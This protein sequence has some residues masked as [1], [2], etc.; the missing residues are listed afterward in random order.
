MYFDPSQICL[1]ILCQP[2]WLYGLSKQTTEERLDFRKHTNLNRAILFF[3][4]MIL[5]LFFFSIFILFGD[6][7][8]HHTAII[9]ILYCQPTGL[10]QRQSAEHFSIGDTGRSLEHCQ[11]TKHLPWK[12]R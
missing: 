3:K 4:Y 1:Q 8:Q 9:P 10:L 12:N 7:Q 6:K 2:S 5:N 11:N